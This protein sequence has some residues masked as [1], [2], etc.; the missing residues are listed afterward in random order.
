MHYADPCIHVFTILRVGALIMQIHPFIFLYI[1]LQEQDDLHYADLCILLFQ[2]WEDF[3][4][5]W[6]PAEYGGVNQ[7]YVPSDKIWLPDIVLYNK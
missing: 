3:A 7:I 4:L 1:L 5:R 6:E 2:E